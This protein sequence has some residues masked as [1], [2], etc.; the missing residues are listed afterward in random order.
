MHINLILEK[1][2]D[3]RRPGGIE[4]EGDREVLFHG[5]YKPCVINYEKL[6]HYTACHFTSDMINM[7][8]L[9]GPSSC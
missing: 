2:C 7:T 4:R 3:K 9:L 5:S 8:L 6:F 1:T